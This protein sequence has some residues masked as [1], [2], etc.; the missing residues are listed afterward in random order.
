MKKLYLYWISILFLCTAQPTF[1]QGWSLDV[2]ADG[3]TGNELYLAYYL[4]NA[5]YIRDTAYVAENMFHFEGRDTLASG[6]YLIVFPPDNKF[7][8]LML[9]EGDH[10]VSIKVDMD[11]LQMPYEIKGSPETSLFYEYV[12]F[13]QKRRPVSDSLR[14]ILDTVENN[15]ILETQ[16]KDQIS[17]LDAEVRDYQQNILDQHPESITALL[18]QANLDIPTPEFEGTTD[19][20]QM[21]TYLYVKEH[22]FDNVP[23]TDPRLLRTPVLQQKVD[24]YINR[25]TPQIPDSLDS[26]ID[27]ILGLLDP[28]GEAFKIYV[29]YFLN[30][31]AKS[32]IVGMDAVYVHM[33][34][35]YY[36]NGLATWT[37]SAQLNKILKNA[38]T[39][40]PLLIGKTAPDL[41]MLDREN[42]PIRLH[43]IDAPYTVLF[44]WDPDC[45]HCKKAIPDLVRFYQEYKPRGIEVFSVCTSLQDEAKKCWEA[46]D[47]RNMGEWVNVVDP[48]LRSRFKQI[49]DVRTTPQI[50]ILDKDKKI[51]MKKIGADQLAEVMDRLMENGS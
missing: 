5:Q 50:Y 11:E 16:L 17:I 14:D 34:D 23:M 44:F 40:R 20:V 7:F 51:I 3:F 26:S 22:Y 21:Q 29:V 39:L 43:S 36:A 27:K 49:Y 13:L 25:L 2:T 6:V 15:A 9:D 35:T 37:D 4:G 38:E 10:H 46:I 41:L 30:Q 12:E 28:E 18:I 47:E 19:E 33:V 8:Q 24:Y 45:G 32:K 31:Y 1:S 42:H 48:Y